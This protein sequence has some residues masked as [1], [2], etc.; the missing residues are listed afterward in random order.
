MKN[1]VM[2]LPETLLNVLRLLSATVGLDDERV[3]SRSV[4]SGGLHRCMK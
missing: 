4:V 1:E 3:C 2:E